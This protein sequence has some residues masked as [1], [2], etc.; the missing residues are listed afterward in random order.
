MSDKRQ[1]A[2]V[3][4][5]WAKQVPK[6]SG[7]TGKS[8]CKHIP[9]KC[10]APF[11]CVHKLGSFIDVYTHKIILLLCDQIHL[12]N[13]SDRSGCHRC[14]KQILIL[15]FKQVQSKTVSPQMPA[16]PLVLGDLGP[17]KPRRLLSFS[18]P[19]R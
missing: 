11:A 17:R 19:P 7:P 13:E 5:C 12:F 15:F 6:H 10:E 4:G 3:Q 1:R 18:S 14:R 8:K 16:W 9:V 2:R